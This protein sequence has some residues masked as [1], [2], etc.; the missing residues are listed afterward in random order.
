[1]KKQVYTMKDVAKLAGVTQP[2]VS[3]VINGTA[4]ISK[5]VTKRVQNAIKEL[6]Y[7]P[8]ALAK[9][10][11]TNTTKTIGLIM[12]DISNGYYATLAK[13]A[14][15]IFANLGYISF[16]TC[17]DYDVTL[18]RKLLE[19]LLR[20]NVDG[21]IIMYSLTDK[22]LLKSLSFSG[23]PMIVID[24]VQNESIPCAIYADSLLGGYLA[25]DY[26][27]KKKKKKRIAYLSEKL[28]SP[29]LKMRLDG[30]K[31]ALTEANI[32]IDN[33]IIIVEKDIYDKFDMGLMLG[34]KI[35]G[36]DVDAVFASSD[37]L[38]FGIMRA[39]NEAKIRVPKD[40]ALVGYDD[41]PMAALATPALT[42]VSQPVY[43][44]IDLAVEQLM[45]QID[46]DGTCKKEIILK[47][48]LII[49][50]TT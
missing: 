21:I 8:N 6:N 37:A 45:I 27:I 14:E 42:S 48:E 9:G 1:M 38:A 43:T 46:G 7:R 5:E 26:L 22:E 49:R 18:E 15:K 3:H 25:T 20:Y 17:T 47:P 31:K 36:R 35:A 11:K 24:E 10:L 41:L 32:P 23:I 34:R 28:T 13:V 40:I 2:T 39:L 50:E 4:S 16:L 29:I 44:Q 19:Q 12:P 30:Y 33:N